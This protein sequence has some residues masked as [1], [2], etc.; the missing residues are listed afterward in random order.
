MEQLDSSTQQLIE[1]LLTSG[2]VINFEGTHNGDVNI[3]INNSC[4]SQ[5]QTCD[6]GDG[7]DLVIDNGEPGEIRFEGNGGGNDGQP[8]EGNDGQHDDGEGKVDQCRYEDYPLQTQFTGNQEFRELAKENNWDMHGFITDWANNHPTDTRITSEFIAYIYDVICCRHLN[9]SIDMLL[10][11][12]GF[13]ID[14]LEALLEKEFID[15]RPD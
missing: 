5:D 13:F 11:A 14:E 8:N 4:C 6:C 9:E 12:N 7:G 10:T 15:V 2:T 3:Y 1:S